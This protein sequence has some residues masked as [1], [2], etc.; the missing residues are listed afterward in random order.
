MLDHQLHYNSKPRHIKY[1]QITKT[2]QLNQLVTYQ[3][4]IPH[5]TLTHTFSCNNSCK[6]NLQSK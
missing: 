2:N 4:S 6:Q 3:T 1:L 5:T